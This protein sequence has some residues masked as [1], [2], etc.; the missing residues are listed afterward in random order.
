MDQAQPQIELERKVPETPELKLEMLKLKRQVGGYYLRNLRKVG[1]H[2]SASIPRQP[3]RS[4][5]VPSARVA[6]TIVS[7]RARVV[8]A[9]VAAARVVVTAAR[10]VVRVRVAAARVAA[11]AV[12]RVAGAVRVVARDRGPPGGAMRVTGRGRGGV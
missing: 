12:R 4:A 6:S 5:V 7:A 10:V 2:K 11:A 8:A 9:R 1:K 3:S